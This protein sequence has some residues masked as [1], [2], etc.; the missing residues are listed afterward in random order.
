MVKHVVIVLALACAALA[1]KKAA[2]E[3]STL[4]KLKGTASSHFDSSLPDQQFSKW[5]KRLVHPAVP[6]YQETSCEGNGSATAA[7]SQCYIVTA[8][9]GPMQRVTLRF[10]YDAEHGDFKYLDGMLEPSDP[11]NKRMSRKLQKLGDLP[12][13]VHPEGQ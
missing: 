9:A 8:L 11:R 7:K 2:F 5:F 10:A 1:Q 4:D 12:A 13:M 3:L 6:D